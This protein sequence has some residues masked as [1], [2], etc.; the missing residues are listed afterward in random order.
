M[1]K[2][3][4]CVFLALCILLSYFFISPAKERQARNYRS[5]QLQKT[6][7]RHNETERTDFYDVKGELT[8]AADAG[9]ATMIKTN[10]EQ[11]VLEQYY[12]ETGEPIS[13]YNQYYAILREYDERGNNTR[14][15]YLDEEGDPCII[16]DGY[17]TEAR[18]YNEDNQIISTRYYDIEGNPINTPL[19]GYGMIN[20]YDDYGN[21]VRIR[22]IDVFNNPI[23]TR[24][25][26]ASVIRQYYT[27]DRPNQGRVI[28]E[29]YYDAQGE[30]VALSLGQYGIYKEYNE[31]GQGIIIVYLDEKGEPIATKKGYTKIIRT[32]A[33][34][35]NV[36]TEQYY[37]LNGN[38]LPLSEGQYGVRNENG[39][40]VYLNRNGRE[41]FSIRNLLN[42]H[43][44]FAIL[45]AIGII[46][47]SAL[48]NRKWAI[49]LLILYM[50]VIIYFTLMFRDNNNT[51]RTI[52]PFWYY[53]KLFTSS[54]ARSDII[55]NIWLFVPLGAVLYK[56]YPRSRILFVPVTISVII[57]GVQYAAGIGYC[58][59]DD[60]I[61]NSLGG[62]IGFISCKYITNYIH[63]KIKRTE[64]NG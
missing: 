41:S 24:Q 57:E 47:L 36:A 25:G 28:K 7:V 14:N 50:C 1:E 44:R 43:P 22:F 9:Y 2:W 30:P 46:I 42:N 37:D 19:F 21:N 18:E 38:P 10:T 58:E 16:K 33:A 59:L 5:S 64:N 3:I 23:V 53:R 40:Q 39:Q 54:T 34:D 35:N 17:A 27:G 55:K 62:I 29:F 15:T 49:A 61:S 52:E 45:F 60:L 6:I 11:G 20:E 13:R 31:L 12:D 51:G 56:L 48:I 32:F 26:Y 4:K 8:V 63:C